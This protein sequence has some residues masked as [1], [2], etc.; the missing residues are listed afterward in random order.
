VRRREIVRG[1]YR[2]EGTWGQTTPLATLETKGELR[3]DV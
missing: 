3:C 2:E 1:D